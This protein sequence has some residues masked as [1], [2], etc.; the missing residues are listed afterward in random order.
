MGIYVST[1][2]HIC[3]CMAI[4]IHVYIYTIDNNFVSAE[5]KVSRISSFTFLS[6]VASLMVIEVSNF[7]SNLFQCHAYAHYLLPYYIPMAHVLNLFFLVLEGCTHISSHYIICHRK[8]SDIQ[9][10]MSE[11]YAYANS[12]DFLLFIW[13][14][15]LFIIY[16]KR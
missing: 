16:T 14:M 3:S 10:N 8:T 5:Q 7:H 4:Y 2:T 9:N 15:Y 12:W 11:Y 1:Y 13:R 6:M